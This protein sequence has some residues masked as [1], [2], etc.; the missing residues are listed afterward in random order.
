MDLS[1]LS[2]EVLVSA[3]THPHPQIPVCIAL[4]GSKLICK[5]NLIWWKSPSRHRIFQ[6]GRASDSADSFWHEMYF[7]SLI[8]DKWESIPC[9]PLDHI[10]FCPVPS[11]LS[12]HLAKAWRNESYWFSRARSS[13]FIKLCVNG[14]WEPS[15]SSLFL[16]QCKRR[17]F[18]RGSYQNPALLLSGKWKASCLVSNMF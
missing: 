9:A 3:R 17:R 1:A 16:Q 15:A 18:D 14:V 12:L 10:L 11:L 2:S 8:S 13:Y 7:S 4:S 6:P 5:M